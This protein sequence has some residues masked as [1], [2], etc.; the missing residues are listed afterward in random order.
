MSAEKNNV[1]AIRQID[2]SLMRQKF[3]LG[4]RADDFERSVTL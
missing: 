3:S 4:R 2:G 1:I